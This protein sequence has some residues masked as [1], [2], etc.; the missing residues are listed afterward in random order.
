M[1]FEAIAV[2]FGEHLEFADGVAY[3]EFIDL[4]EELELSFAG[5][6]DVVGVAEALGFAEFYSGEDGGCGAF[7][8]VE[9]SGV[10]FGVVEEEAEIVVGGV[11]C[12]FAFGVGLGV[13]G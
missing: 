6:W 11:A 8:D 5:L 7:V 4:R 9:L 2:F 10:A 3:V 12:Y 1:A 13:A